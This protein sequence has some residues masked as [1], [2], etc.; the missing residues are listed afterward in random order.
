VRT[1]NSSFIFYPNTFI[2][3]TFIFDLRFSNR[4]SRALFATS[5]P[6]IKGNTLRNSRRVAMNSHTSRVAMSTVAFEPMPQ[7]LHMLMPAPKN[8]DPVCAEGTLI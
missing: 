1:G 2:I 7:N 4:C 5:L 3:N 8:K 6:Y